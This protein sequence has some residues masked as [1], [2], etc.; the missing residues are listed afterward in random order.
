MFV[1]YNGPIKTLTIRMVKNVLRFG[2]QRWGGGERMRIYLV[3]AANRSSYYRPKGRSRRGRSSLEPMYKICFVWP[4]ESPVGK[5]SPPPSRYFVLD[6]FPR[7]IIS[8]MR[9]YITWDRHQGTI[10]RVRAQFRRVS[11]HHDQGLRVR[12]AVE[13][14]LRHPSGRHGRHV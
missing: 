12:Y 5:F 8:N 2:H 7:R 6:P 9:P 13:L 3:V 10:V 4:I 14:R 1:N 11:V